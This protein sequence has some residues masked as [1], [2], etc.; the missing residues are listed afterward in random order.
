[1]ALNKEIEL[2]NGI[3]VTYHRI[4]SI[5]KITNNSCL[6]EIASYINESKRE[7]EKR[8][9]ETNSPMNIFIYT[10]YISK[11]YDEDETIKDLYEYLKTI[12]KFADATDI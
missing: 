11:E 8:A 9:L 2:D 1:M 10:D 5:H 12:D 4:A 7:E 3:V 6:L